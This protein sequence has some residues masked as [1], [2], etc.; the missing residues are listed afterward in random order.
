MHTLGL[1]VKDVEQ[2]TGGAAVDVADLVIMGDEC[3][4]GAQDA[5][6]DCDGYDLGGKSCTSL[7]YSSGSLGCSPTCTFD[8]SACKNDGPVS[9]PN[10]QKDANEQCDGADLGGKSCTSLGWSGGSLGCSPACM[11]DTSSCTSD[12]PIMCPDNKKEGNEQCDGNDFGGASCTSLGYSGG[13]LACT[14]S[15]KLDTSGCMNDVPAPCPNGKKDPGE[16]CDGADFG[17]AS[18][19]SQGFSG[20]SLNCTGS[21]SFDTSEC[22]NEPMCTFDV[23]PKAPASSSAAPYNCPGGIV[24]PVSGSLDALGNLTISSPG[25]PD[26]YGAGNYRVVVF[27]SN[28]DLSQQCKPFNAVKATKVLNQKANSITF[29]AFASLL[30]C[31]G[32][33]KAYCIQKEDGGNV[34]HF[35]SGKLVASYQ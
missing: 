14:A 27:D 2:C 16:Q 6:E 22:T 18:C 9:C 26:G 1:W 33:A 35:C 31:G 5:S 7:G 13:S 20:G 8:I 28:A 17:G 25:K 30:Q 32:A 34:D 12:E 23:N 4:D 10:G 15:C 24:M 21:C 3:G 11:F 19:V 29:P